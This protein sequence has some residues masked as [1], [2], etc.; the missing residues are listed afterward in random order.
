MPNQVV[1]Y[2]INPI[3]ISITDSGGGIAYQQEATPAFLRSTP[4][5]ND[6]KVV[7]ETT[8]ADDAAFGVNMTAQQK[9]KQKEHN[10][11]FDKGDIIRV[12]ITGQ[13]YRPEL[14]NP[15]FTPQYV[16]VLIEGVLLW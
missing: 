14:T 4:T 9:I 11:F 6:I 10:Y 3:K 13:E 5:P 1:Q 16:D 15:I 7:T 12:K 8:P 2:G